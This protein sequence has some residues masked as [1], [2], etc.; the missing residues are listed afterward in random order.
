MSGWGI[1][2]LL[3]ESE[4]WPFHRGVEGGVMVVAG[5][6]GL[7]GAHC[8]WCITSLLESLVARASSLAA[9]VMAC[10]R[11]KSSAALSTCPRGRRVRGREGRAWGGRLKGGKELLGSLRLPYLG[12]QLGL[13]GFNRSD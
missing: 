7:R 5:W 9:R 6:G 4:R 8:A 11:S 3:K 1:T 2:S 10:A 12:E 13:I